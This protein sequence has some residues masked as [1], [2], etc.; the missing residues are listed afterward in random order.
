[1]NLLETLNALI[2]REGKYS[3]H[4]ADKG[5]ETMWGITAAT[6]RAFG[7]AGPMKD[8][9]R[10]VAEAI[11]TE[12]YWLQPK[13]DKVASLDPEIAEELLDTGVNMG[14]SVAGKFL[15]R[16]LNV[17][18]QGDKLY[19]NLTVDGLIGNMTLHALKTLLAARGAGGRTVLLRMLNAQQ[20]VRYM[21]IAEANVSQE[22]FEYGWQLNRVGII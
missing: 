20:S 16:A 12:R 17:L 9:S 3:N 8:M 6:A 4:Q 22:A 11:Y 5:G 19:P 15:Q 7:Y 2:G 13:F 1:M 18:N 21:E 14:P 10:T